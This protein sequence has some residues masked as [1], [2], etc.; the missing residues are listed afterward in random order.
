[1]PL[2]HYKAVT[3]TGEVQE[4]DLDASAQAVVVERL[5][6]M[7]L[8]PILVEETSSA[9]TMKAGLR[10]FGKASVSQE[11]VAVFTQELATLLKAGDRKSVV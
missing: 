6:S 11:D 10:V 1:M 8:M 7:G 9:V 2:Y 4:G 5:Q 3:P